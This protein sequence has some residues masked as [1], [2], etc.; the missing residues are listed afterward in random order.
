[1]IILVL[2]LFLAAIYISL[3]MN[4]DRALFISIGLVLIGI[5]IGFY[6]VLNQDS[7]ENLK[8]SKGAIPMPQFPAQIQR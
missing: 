6:V 8:K 2:I 4:G 7:Y 1:M 5:V 3:F